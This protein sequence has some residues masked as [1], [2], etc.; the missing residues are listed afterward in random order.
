MQRK[1]CF[2]RMTLILLSLLLF[3]GAGNIALAAPELTVGNYKLVASKRVSRFEFEYTYK[4]DITN[5]AQGALAVSASLTIN[6]PGVTLLDGLLD[7]GDV[8]GGGVLTSL[9]TFALRQDRRYSF[10]LDS[11]QWTIRATD[12]LRPVLIPKE[13]SVQLPVLQD[14][15]VPLETLTVSTLLSE[16]T[17][18]AGETT[19]RMTFADADKGQILF[20][21]NLDGTP[22]L[23]AY[24]SSVEIRDGTANVTLDSIAR[25]L[26]ML[27]PL[28]LGFRD[29]DRLSILAYAQTDPL[30]QDLK[31]EITHALTVEPRNLLEHAVFPKVYE[32]ALT[33]VIHAVENATS[34]ALQHSFDATAAAVVALAIVGKETDVHLTDIPGSEI[35]TV[36]PTTLFHG[37]NIKGQPPKLLA[38]KESFFNLQFGWP[39]ITG[40]TDP[41]R[42]AL[43]LG[44]GNFYVNF[45]KFGSDSDA[46]RMAAMANFARAFCIIIDAVTWCPIS[47][48]GIKAGLEEGVDDLLATTASELFGDVSISSVFELA[49][50]IISILEKEDEVY[51]SVMRILYK[52]SAPLELQSRVIFLSA[53][54]KVLK[55]YMA[56]DPNRT[57]PFL[58]DLVAHAYPPEINFCISQNSGVLSSTCQ[59]IP[60]SAVINKISPDT[61]YVGDTVTFDASQSSD[62]LTSADALSVRW[63]FNGDGAFDTAWS[64]QKQVTWSYHNVGSYDVILEVKDADGFVG[65]SVFTVVV[66]ALD[67]VVVV[68]FDDIPVPEEGFGFIPENYAGLSWS[69]N[70]AVMSDSYYS[71]IYQNTYG[72]PSGQNA[73]YNGYGTLTVSVSNNSPFTFRGASFAGWGFFNA[74][75]PTRSATSITVEGYRQGQ[76]MSSKTMGLL[77][78]GYQWLQADLQ[79]IDELR[80]ISSDNQR[81]WLMD[82]LTIEVES[83][84]VGNGSW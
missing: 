78:S 15:N 57:I 14:H 16:H 73:A 11:L 42:E 36:N 3:I 34:A 25:G 32:H 64:T 83:T 79:G 60:P 76:L 53:L 81:W 72:S 40:F 67:A 77:S 71:S 84:S 45:S 20:V 4:A 51:K 35:Y 62:D 5:R 27:N 43:N 7:F 69:S 18:T 41:V 37:I 47:N 74:V 19:A 13:V 55:V 23:V 50:G 31:S 30:Y 75:D 12:P 65:R 9:D 8:S 10:G 70:W 22:L 21:A 66:R 17:L 63:D 33:L 46:A 49:D 2:A 24:I 82:D 1:N 38:G 28:M 59:Y 39:P 58:Y 54:K 61:V 56:L 29:I 80:F 52:T 68:N 48:D 6:A 26:I 44:D